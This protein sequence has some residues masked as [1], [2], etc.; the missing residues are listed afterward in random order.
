M[1]RNEQCMQQLVFRAGGDDR[2][3]TRD[4]SA[5]KEVVVAVTNTLYSLRD[6]EGTIV[7]PRPL[8]SRDQHALRVHGSGIG[9]RIGFM[10]T[11]P[12]EEGVGT[13]IEIKAKR[14]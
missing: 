3:P 5:V 13:L 2:M 9:N 4:P 1:R 11:I 8:R 14:K 6:R 7:F 10:V 12:L